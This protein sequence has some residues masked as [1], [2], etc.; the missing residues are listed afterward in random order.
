[1]MEKPDFIEVRKKLEDQR[2]LLLQQ[3]DER[4][5]KSKASE[6]INPDRSDLAIRYD[7]RERY[8]VLGSQA[9]KQ[10]EEIEQAIKRLDEGSYGACLDCGKAI[11][12]GRLRALP[13]A[14]LCIH[15]QAKHEKR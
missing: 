4:E 10:I 14:S 7:Q 6:V 11:A 3:I 12:P 9:E 1:M 8:V 5:L 2:K 13:Y 15:C